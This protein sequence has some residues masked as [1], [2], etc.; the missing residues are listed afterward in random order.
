MRRGLLGEPGVRNLALVTAT[1]GSAN[2]FGFVPL[3]VQLRCHCILRGLLLSEDI[4]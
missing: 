1:E 4:G 2:D 3:C